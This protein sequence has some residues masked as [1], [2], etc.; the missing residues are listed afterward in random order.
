MTKLSEQRHHLCGETVVVIF[1]DAP[2][3]LARKKANLGSWSAPASNNL[4]STRLSRTRAAGNHVYA[5]RNSTPSAE[6]ILRRIVH[7]IK[8]LL[9]VRGTS[10][11]GDIRETSQ[12][13]EELILVVVLSKQLYVET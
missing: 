13:F 11:A 4:H 2:V 8:P 3:G 5:S 9:K 7:G 1:W 6:D 12:V 10:A